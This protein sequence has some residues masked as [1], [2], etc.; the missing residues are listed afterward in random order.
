MRDRKGVDLDVRESGDELGGAKGGAA[1]IK[2]YVKKSLFSIKGKI[3]NK[4]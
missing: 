3:L 1:I 2:T 4:S